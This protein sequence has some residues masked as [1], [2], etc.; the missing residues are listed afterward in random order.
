MLCL[1]RK[2]WNASCLSL[3][4][5][6]SREK[7]THS[8]TNLGELTS[9]ESLDQTDGVLFVLVSAAAAHAGDDR[10][11]AGTDE[12][13]VR[14]VKKGSKEEKGRHPGS[15]W[16]A[17]RCH[18]CSL[19]A[20]IHPSAVQE[21]SAL[22][23]LIS[24][25]H[26]ILLHPTYQSPHIVLFVRGYEFFLYGTEMFRHH[27]NMFTKLYLHLVCLVHASHVN[28]QLKQSSSCNKCK[29]HL[30]SVLQAKYLPLIILTQKC[31]IVDSTT[32]LTLWISMVF[33]LQRLLYA[34]SKTTS[35]W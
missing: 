13:E 10:S 7:Q 25:S 26:H 20:N 28:V 4:S 2:T 30:S 27:T 16:S 23:L 9:T 34:N 31:K 17:R 35:V 32:N 5:R 21:L 33:R 12:D 1:P 19:P 18:F 6:Y 29:N 24:A 14:R 22:L 8:L 15:C 11:D 3:F